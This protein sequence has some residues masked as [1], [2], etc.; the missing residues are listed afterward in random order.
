ML[1]ALFAAAAEAVFSYTLD[2]LEL[3][4]RL[5][6]WL[7]RN[8]AKLAY[9][10][11]L[12]RTYAAFARQYP[13]FTASLFNESFLTGEATPEL[14]KF[15]TRHQY[16]DHTQLV[17]L[18]VKSVAPQTEAGQQSAEALSKREDLNAASAYFVELLTS[19]LKHEAALQ[20]LFDSRVL[21]SLPAIEAKLDQLTNAL[22][23][24]M[25]VANNYE[26]TVVIRSGGVDFQTQAVTIGGDVVGRDKIVDDSIHVGDISGVQAVAI[27]HGASASVTNNYFVGDFVTLDDLY[28]R[29]D[30]VFQRVRVQDFVGREW[31]TAKVDHFLNDE[32]RKSGVFL[33]VGEAGVGKTSFMAHLVSERRY[34]HLFAEQVPGDVNVSRALQ[35]LGAQLVARYQIDPYK[36]KGTLPAIAT[37]PDFLDKLLRLAADKLS[38]GE[39]IVIVCDALDEAGTAP[40][41]N[42]F[43][44]PSVLPD[45]V[46]FILSQRPVATVKLS[47]KA[48]LVKEIIDAAGADN[49][50]DVEQY[51]IAVSHRPEISNQLHAHNYTEADFVRILKERSGGVWMYLFYVVSEVAAG[52]RAPLDLATLPSGLAGYYTDYWGDWSEGRNGRGDGPAKWDIVYAP[53]LATL[54]AAQLPIDLK[55]LMAWSHVQA[56][57]Y[58]VERLLCRNWRAFITEREIDHTPHFALYHASL[59]DFLTRQVDRQ[60]LTLEAEQLIDELSHRTRDAHARIIEYYYQRCNG[61]WVTLVD[62]D[63]ACMHLCLHLSASGNDETVYQLVAMNNAWAEA[64]YAKEESYAGYLIDLSRAWQYA[65]SEVNWSIGRQI[66]CA[67]IKSSIHSLADKIASELLELLVDTK[68]WNPARALSHISQI[69]DQRQQAH[70]LS[71]LAMY[72][73]SEIKPEMLSTARALSDGYARVI[74][75]TGLW[76]YL[77]EEIQAEV[78]LKAFADACAIPNE[79]RRARAL[80]SVIPCLSESAKIEALTVARAISRD[81]LRI[82]VLVAIAANVPHS[83]KDSV[84]AEVLAAIH[85]LS[86]ESDRAHVISSAMPVLPDDLKPEVVA[87]ARTIADM[88][89]RAKVLSGFVPYLSGSLKIDVRNEALAIASV[90]TDEDIYAEVLTNVAPDIPE[91]LAFEVLTTAR[92]MSQDHARARALCALISWLPAEVK[93]DTTYEAFVASCEATKSGTVYLPNTF[94]YLAPNFPASFQREAISVIQSIPEGWDRNE[95]LISLAPYLNDDLKVIVVSE[96]LATTRYLLDSSTC[97][98]ALNNLASYLPHNVQADAIAIANILMKD[99]VSTNAVHQLTQSMSDSAASELIGNMTESLSAIRAITSTHS[100]A[101]ALIDL[102]PYLSGSLRDEVCSEALS[103]ARAISHERSPNEYLRVRVL[104]SL[105]PYVSDASK[106]V[107]FR[108]ALAAARA[109]AD[110]ATFHLPSPFSFLAPYLFLELKDEVFAAVQS[111]R[112]DRARVAALCSLAQHLSDRLKTEVIAAA[113]VLSDVDDRVLALIQ[114]APYLSEGLRLESIIEAFTIVSNVDWRRSVLYTQIIGIWHELQFKGIGMQQWTRALYV[115][116]CNPRQELLDDL[117]ALLPLIE[118]LGGQAAIEDFYY[119]LRDV[120]TWWP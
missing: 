68:I 29:P 67:L 78:S 16:P 81:V 65:E 62:D 50:H 52:S 61:D 15:L 77:P 51:L 31:L 26:Q 58:E 33:L 20:P 84:I 80:I 112:N 27:G 73:P 88:A 102:I 108:E 14:A 109:N 56:S 71:R 54:A 40:N 66:R 7:K 30:A 57:E 116:A 92:A 90:T 101:S 5:R 105:I 46:Y 86:N 21:E 32:K 11:A 98:M 89:T 12:A 79:N 96:I 1:E 97:V 76:R 113:H 110:E 99:N 100:R 53:L 95:S 17:L 25:T 82:D 107:V 23:Q 119:A 48:D 34:L 6:D 87:A 83:V 63:Y 19:E 18:W 106:T 69:S 75:L 70:S 104:S 72:V 37:F 117:A 3:A 44:L 35:S 38:A 118:H 42:V 111:I 64:K 60:G 49:L 115:L 28:I 59:R 94:V 4:E 8:T 43:G 45:G 10:H 120:T 85:A 39:K 2:T 103:V 9:Q 91:E 13:E 114:L 41:G 93:A 74:A 55:L 22:K 24:A 47:V 36:E